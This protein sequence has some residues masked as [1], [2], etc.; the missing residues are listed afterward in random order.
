MSYKKGYLLSILFIF[1]FYFS[2]YDII[3]RRENFFILLIL[4]QILEGGITSLIAI[5]ILKSKEYILYIKIFLSSY[6][7]VLIIS[8]ICFKIAL[9]NSYFQASLWIYF[10]DWLTCLYVGIACVTHLIFIYL[11]KK[12]L[13]SK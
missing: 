13:S 12:H 4:I 5:K 7:F 9:K 11:K 8:I 1:L 6:I 2:I 3:P 10:P